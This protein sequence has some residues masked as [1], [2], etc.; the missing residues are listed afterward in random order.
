MPELPEVESFK[1]YVDNTSLHQT[2]ETIRFAGKDLLLHT[3]EKKLR[4]TLTGNT[5]DNAL[6]SSSIC[7]I[8]EYTTHFDFRRGFDS[9][10]NC[11]GIEV[12]CEDI[13]WQTDDLFFLYLDLF[14]F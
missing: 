9:L 1:R 13:R 6:D 10:K 11:C 4:D 3:S 2:I 8:Q 12:V 5:L 7:F 14:L